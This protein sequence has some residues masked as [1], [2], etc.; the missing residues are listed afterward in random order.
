MTNK[1]KR[2]AF[3]SDHASPLACIGTVD[4]G[5]QNV[6]VAQ[7]AEHLAAKGYLVDVYTRR[8][9]ASMDEIVSWQQG[10]RVIHVKAG[11]ECN[12]AKEQML[13]YMQE[14]RDYMTRFII[15]NHLHYELIHANFFMSGLVAAGIKKELD[16]P[17]VITF[18][19]LGSVRRI[20]QADKDRFPKERIEIE[21]MI[22]HEANHIIAEC[23]QDRDDLIAHYRAHPRQISIVPCGFSSSEF[24]P[25]EKKVARG[26][27]G[28]PADCHILLQLG[29][30]VERKGID[31]VI[32]S[33]AYLQS[34]GGKD[35][36]LVIV[37]GDS[38]NMAG[39]ACTEYK[40]LHTLARRLKI[41]DRILFAGRKNR[42]KLKF[43]YNAADL[44][45]TTPWYE[46]FGITPLEAMACGTP[47]IGA[48]VGGI[49]FS[50]KDGV[51]GALVPPRQ[52]KKLAG[53][54]TEIIS[55]QDKLNN[56]R[57]NAIDHVNTWFTWAK[58]AEQID[59]LY[60]YVVSGERKHSSTLI[61]IGRDSRAA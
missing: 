26:L 16:I 11:P 36:R 34:V 12:V 17:F 25:V 10:I 31:N 59:E 52:P 9:D 44:F 20:H 13:Q 22:V 7:L 41:T 51:S 28:L 5:G 24:Y 47:V 18:H 30:M 55:D 29:R 43:Y 50:V 40:R 2:I 8:D 14:F 6:Y 42:E 54:I 56:M 32:K 53:K 57:R 39:S 27:L 60:R 21:E 33:M 1:N 19:A 37:G 4:T 45:I 61:N 23:P 35:F 38:E 58:V 46:P 49:K 15:R 48:N 3:I